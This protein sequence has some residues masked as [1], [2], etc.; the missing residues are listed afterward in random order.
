MRITST[1]TLAAFSL[2]VALSGCLVVPEEPVVQAPIVVAPPPLP[3]CFEVS[4][5]KRV[6]IPAETR[7]VTAISV[8]EN[9][10]YRPIEQRTEQKIITKP[11]EVFYVRVD[12]E[13]GNEV[14][15]TNLCDSTV[16]TGP[17]GPA[18]GEL[19]EPATAG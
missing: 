18:A 11:A 3:A 19:A 6:E 10:P 9:P 17:V 14:E 12:A 7:T 4:Q 1:L 8:I 5:L 16:V 15:V 13:T 2:S